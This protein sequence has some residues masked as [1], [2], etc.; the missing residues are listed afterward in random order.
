MLFGESLWTALI[1]Q[2]KVNVTDLKY[3]SGY[4]TQW[5]G[6]RGAMIHA[7][8]WQGPRGSMIHPTQWQGLR[9]ANQI[10]LLSQLQLVTC[11]FMK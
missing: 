2:Y 11:V 5:Q 10:P 8:Q 7:T 3:S 6:P 4:S 1:V 9:G